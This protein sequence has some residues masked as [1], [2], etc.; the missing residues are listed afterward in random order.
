MIFQGVDFD[1]ADF[2]LRWPRELF[3]YEAKQLL[4]RSDLPQFPQRVVTLCGEAFVDADIER[5]LESEFRTFA[6]TRT[7]DQSLEGAKAL[8]EE[9]IAQPELLRRYTRRRYYAER[10]QDTEQSGQAGQAGQAR[11]LATSFYHLVGEMSESGYFPEILPKICVDDH[12]DW[13]PDPSDKISKNVG[14][15]VAWPNDVRDNNISESVLYSVMEYFHDEA[16]R[17]RKRW[18]HTFG[19]CGS[20]HDDF[21]KRS[22]GVVYRWRVNELLEQHEVW[23]KLGNEGD[24]AGLLIKHAPFSLDYLTSDVT[25]AAPWNDKDEKGKIQ[26]AIRA[27]RRRDATVHDRRKA[28]ASLADILEHYREEFKQVRFTRGDEGDLFQIFNNFAIRHGKK[29][30]KGDY[31]DEY[32]DWIFWT[33]LAAIQLVHQLGIEASPEA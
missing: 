15:P 23:L 25:S 26:S 1:Q 30:E 22:G 3:V 24:E 31:G 32:L 6:W 20:H 33:T 17:P 9:L 27:Y 11:W 18:V 28:V 19:N 12:D 10:L 7:I 13:V 16:Q 5:I 4:R 8:L 2:T 21:S 29:T 14:A